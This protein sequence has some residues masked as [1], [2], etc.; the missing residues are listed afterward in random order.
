ME[1]IAGSIWGW[2]DEAILGRMGVL[3]ENVRWKE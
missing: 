1:E 2:T 3:M